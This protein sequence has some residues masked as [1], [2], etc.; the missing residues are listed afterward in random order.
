MTTDGDVCT[1]PHL[2]TCLGARYEPIMSA[3]TLYTVG[4]ESEPPEI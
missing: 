1:T 4:M 2:L 3:V